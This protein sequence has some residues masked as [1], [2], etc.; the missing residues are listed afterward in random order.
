MKMFDLDDWFKLSWKAKP[1]K[2]KFT[3][4]PVQ[5]ENKKWTWVVNI[6]SLA[7]EMKSTAEF[8]SREDAIEN[9]KLCFKHFGL[10]VS[11]PE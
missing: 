10:T 11:D 2:T 6:G 7:V 8:P 9:V 3:I 5:L 4:T 1:Q